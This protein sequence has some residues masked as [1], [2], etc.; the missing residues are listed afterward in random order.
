MQAEKRAAIIENQQPLMVQMPIVKLWRRSHRNLA[1]GY[2]YDDA[3]SST[4]E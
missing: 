2:I 1:M 3:C 4:K